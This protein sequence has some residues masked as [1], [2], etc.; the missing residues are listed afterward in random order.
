MGKSRKSCNCYIIWVISKIKSERPHINKAD[1]FK[2]NCPCTRKVLLELVVHEIKRVMCC[3]C[4]IHHL[5]KW[6]W[7]RFLE[8]LRFLFMID[9]FS[10]QTNLSKVLLEKQSILVIPGKTPDGRKGIALFVAA[11]S[12]SRS[13]FVSPSVRPSVFRLSEKATFRVSDIN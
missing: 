3:C 2:L 1:R 7:F 4:C 9:Q 5:N 6:I 10:W 13:L 8:Y 11:S 12:S